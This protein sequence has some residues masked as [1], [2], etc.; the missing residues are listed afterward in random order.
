MIV[1]EAWHLVLFRVQA[2]IRCKI[3]FVM[4]SYAVD[5][6]PLIKALQYS[7]LSLDI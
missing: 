1:V 7:I 6:F 5:T 4:D 3:F 2:K